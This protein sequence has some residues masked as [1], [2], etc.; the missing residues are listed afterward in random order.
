M[1]TE[2][3]YEEEKNS[4]K[5]EN[6]AANI[7]DLKNVIRLLEEYKVPYLL[8][9]GYAIMMK[10]NQRTTSDIDILLPMGI[11][12][13]KKIKAA[14]GNLPENTVKDVKDEWFLEDETIRVADEFTVDLLFKCG[15]GNYNYENLLQYSEEKEFDGLTIKTINA[16][17]LWKTKQTGRPK[18]INDLIFLQSLMGNE[19][20]I[21]EDLLN[22][23]FSIKDFANKIRKKIF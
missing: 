14:L 20:K 4:G 18:D 13:G 8:I 5:S 23:S 3:S 16:D 22:K 6:R 2:E 19:V 10:G 17:G 15:G 12:V 1:K 7:N 21:N 11:E 9:G